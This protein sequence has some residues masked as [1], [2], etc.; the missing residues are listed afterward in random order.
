M[1]TLPARSTLAYSGPTLLCLALLGCGE[2]QVDL[3]VGTLERDRIELLVESNEPIVARQ[4]QDG[5]KVKAGDLILQQDTSRLSARLGQLRAARDQAA[6]RLAELERGP[7]AEAILEMEA[8]LKAAQARTLTALSD[9]KRAR[10]MFDRKL[11]SQAILDHAEG[12]WKAS[13]AEERA[14][15]EELTALLNGTTAEELQQARAA[16]Q[17]ADAQ[18]ASAQIDIDRSEIRAPV[19]G[20]MDKLLYQVGERPAAGTTVAVIMADT[21]VYARVYVP[22]TLRAHVVPGQQLN[23]QLDGVGQ[24]ITGVVRWVSADASFTPYFALTEYDR[25]RLSYLAEIDLPPRADQFPSGLPLTVPVSA[26]VDQ[27]TGE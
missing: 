9:Y 10:E 20:R 2:P 26:P 24:A 21:R 6:A 23:V 27:T 14:I 22:E 11:S 15:N 8:N 3:L 17:A 4:A 12:S 1:N 7:R 18:V 13:A 16:L 5:Q 25:S 19:D